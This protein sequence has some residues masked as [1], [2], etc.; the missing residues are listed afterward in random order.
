MCWISMQADAGLTVG[1]TIEL[2]PNFCDR[3]RSIRIAISTGIIVKVDSIGI[4]CVAGGQSHVLTPTTEKTV[5]CLDNRWRRE[6]NLLVCQSSC[7]RHRRV[8]AFC[9]LLG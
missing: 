8:S 7:S 9:Y 3:K 5:L 4:V 1:S 2:T 6:R